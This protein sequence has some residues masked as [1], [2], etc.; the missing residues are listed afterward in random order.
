MVLVFY[1]PS[2]K[3]FQPIDWPAASL[4]SFWLGDSVLLIGG[5]IVAGLS[6]LNR[7]PWA[8]IAVWSVA[9]T[10]WYPTFVCIATSLQTDEA[11][12]ASAMMVSMAGLTLA[13]ATIHGNAA[14]SPAT[15]RVTPMSKTS[16]LAWTFA[17][18]LVFWSVFLWIIPKGIMEV[19]HHI[20]WPTFTHTGQTAVSLV[21]LGVA[22]VLGL[23]SGVT[24]AWQGDG[25]PLPTATAPKLVMA[26]PYRFVRNPMA[27]AGIVQGIAVGWLLGSFAVV[28]Y[29]IAGAFAWHWFV[30]PVEEA[31]L[32]NRFGDSYQQYRRDVR[33]WIPTIPV[34]PK[35]ETTST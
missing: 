3:W 31:D 25:T 4:I 14:Q 24:M 15:I 26:G 33:L 18:T 19:E 32:K 13:M 23:W 22:S 1:P 7:K 30:R 6:V 29:S 35:A 17:Q 28:G 5:S 16:A 11:W 9:A 34:S 21:L 12:I 2:V 10:V 20:G 27:L 8:V